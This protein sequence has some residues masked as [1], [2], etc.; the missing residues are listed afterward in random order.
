M[1]FPLSV[2]TSPDALQLLNFLKRRRPEQVIAQLQA[3]SASK[4]IRLESQTPITNTRPVVASRSLQKVEVSSPKPLA[5]PKPLESPVAVVKAILGKQLG[6][7]NA[8][9][10]YDFTKPTESEMEAYDMEMV[11]AI[12][13]G[14]LKKLR[15]VHASG[16]SLDACNRFGESLIHMA[17]RRGKIDLVTFLI[18]EAKVRVTRRDDYGRIPLHDATW[19]SQPNFDVM[20][21]LLATVPP[22][23]LLAK[24]VRGHT[25]FDYARREHWGAWVKFLNERKA[26]LE[27]RLEEE[28]SQKRDAVKVIA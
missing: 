2:Q 20:D 27:T 3:Q 21:K 28:L 18:D 16:K 17:C 7:K 22:S 24:D 6:E 14:D 12:R 11:N 13:S 4:R 9:A 25:C 23:L 8:T 5:S 15:E 10:N 26:L 1:S 19:T